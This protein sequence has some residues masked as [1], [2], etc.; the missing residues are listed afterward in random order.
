MNLQFII[1][2]Y[3]HFPLV[4]LHLTHHVKEIILFLKLILMLILHIL[5]IM[6]LDILVQLGFLIQMN[7]AMHC[8]IHC[9]LTS[10]LLFLTS[11][12]IPQRLII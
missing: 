12:H 10:P 11:Y 5:M 4:N 1:L 2:K 7:L 3:I 8:H 6:S 9:Q